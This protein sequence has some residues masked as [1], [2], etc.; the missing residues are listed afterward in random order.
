VEKLFFL[1]IMYVW[2]DQ[3]WRVYVVCIQE[4]VSVCI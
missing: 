3:T 1:V 2:D 4:D